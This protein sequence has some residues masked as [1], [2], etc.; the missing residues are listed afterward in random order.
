MNKVVM[1]TE[2]KGV[3]LTSTKGQQFIE[4]DVREGETVLFN[5][6]NFVGMSEE[7]HISTLISVRLSTLLLGEII[8]STATGPGK[9]ILETSGRAEITRRDQI[10]DSLPPERMVAMPRD[11]RMYVESE[12]GPVDVYLSSAYIRPE[13]GGQMIIDVDSQSGAGMGLGRFFLHF[14]WPG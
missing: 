10:A 5:F 1:H 3:T 12:L 14:I 11:T 13:M 8:Y 4:W 7:L 2:D 9:L 6:R